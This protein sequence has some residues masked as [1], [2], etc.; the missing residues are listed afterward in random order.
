MSVP[1]EFDDRLNIPQQLAHEFEVDLN[2][3]V[4]ANHELTMEG[5]DRIEREEMAA[6]DDSLREEP[7]DEVASSI[8]IRYQRN[9]DD[10][11]AAAR[12]LALVGLVTRFQHWISLYARRIEPQR[13]PCN[14]EK[15]IEFLSGELGSGPE[16]MDFF[17]KL[18]DARDSVIHADSEETWEHGKS[19]KVEPGYIVGS[20]V[21]LRKEDLAEAIDKTIEQMKWYDQKLRER[22]M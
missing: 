9:Y 19:R 10:L 16:G 2:C 14:L 15:G 13:K 7:D 3:L 21:E 8:R 1:D 18:K 20:H 4:I 12:N 17:M 5:I 11:R 6:V 22:G